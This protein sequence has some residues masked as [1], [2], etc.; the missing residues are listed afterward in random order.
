MN[1]KN[2]VFC[3]FMLTFAFLLIQIVALWQYDGIK[4]ALAETPTKCVYLTFD[5]GPS[6]KVTPK[7]LDVLK[8]EG[9]KATFFVV[10]KQ[11]ERRKYILER[12]NAEG[13]TVAVHSYSHVYRDIYSSPEKLIADINECNRVIYEAIGKYANVYRFPGGSFSLNENLINAVTDN[14]FRY[15]DWNASFRDAEI[16]KPTAEQLVNAAITTPANSE[17]IVMLAHDTTDKITTVQALKQVIHYY[18]DKGYV[19]K[20]F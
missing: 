12:E 14:G 7:I 17:H 3:A 18:K 11:A 15:V 10:G 9:V 16:Y 5:D 20:K 13:H 4:I 8:E 1:R 6:D 2:T 19:F